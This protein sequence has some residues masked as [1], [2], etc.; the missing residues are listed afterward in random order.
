MK[1][2]K[3][4]FR[5]LE[6]MLTRA[7]W[8]ED[9]WDIYNR[10]VYLQLYKD[11]WHNHNQGGVHFET[12]IEANEIRRKEFPICLHAEEDCPSQARFIEELIALEGDRI[13]GWKGYKTVGTGY[14]VCVRKLPLN[15]K[16]LE[17]RLYEELNRLRQLE[18]GIQAVLNRV[19]QP[20]E[21]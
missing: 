12:F 19:S 14:T 2:I 3:G 9:G 6:K 15:F 21:S 16:N 13:R 20:N 7:S 4:V 11:S 8:F 5:N 17:Q 18:H 10:G 1:N